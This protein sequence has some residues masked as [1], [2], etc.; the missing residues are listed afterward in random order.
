MQPGRGCGASPSPTATA[1]S[2][3]SDPVVGPCTV[4]AWKRGWFGEQIREPDDE[5]QITTPYQ[6]SPYWMVFVD[7]IPPSWTPFLEVYEQPLDDEMLDF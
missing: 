4:R 5:F 2:V 1:P 3:A 6:F 7:P